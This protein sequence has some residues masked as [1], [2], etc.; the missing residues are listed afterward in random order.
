VMEMNPGCRIIETNGLTGKGA[1]ELAGC[2]K[3][4][5]VFNYNENRLRHNAPFSICTLCV[6]EMHIEKKYHRGVL[7]HIN[8]VQEYKG[9]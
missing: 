8:G 2:F 6:G 1:S 4:A 7:R 5:P 9:E 3:D